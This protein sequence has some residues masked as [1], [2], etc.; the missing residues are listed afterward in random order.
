[1]E[2][3]CLIYI[4][5]GKCNSIRAEAIKIAAPSSVRGCGSN[6]GSLRAWFARGFA[7]D[8]LHEAR[9]NHHRRTTALWSGGPGVQRSGVRG[10]GVTFL[11]PAHLDRVSPESLPPPNSQ[12]WNRPK[13]RLVVSR[14]EAHFYPVQEDGLSLPRNRHER[15]GR[16]GRTRTRRIGLCGSRRYDRG[17]EADSTSNS[18]PGQQVRHGL[19]VLLM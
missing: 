9:R 13:C 3:R 18:V 15:E 8:L 2:E 11:V 7:A 5:R 4:R 10:P 12:F 16:S 17:D 19:D 6:L 14:D 1:M